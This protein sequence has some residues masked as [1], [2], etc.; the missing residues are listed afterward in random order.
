M[1]AQPELFFDNLN[2]EMV[3]DVRRVFH[4]PAKRQEPLIRRDRPWEGMLSFSD[5]AWNVLYDPGERLYRCWYESAHFD[6]ERIRQT[7]VDITDPRVAG[8]RICYACSV[9]GLHWEKPELDVFPIGGHPTN[10]VFGDWEAGEEEFGSVHAITVLDD[11]WDAAVDR[12]FKMIFQHVT[13]ASPDV[14]VV[15]DPD[16]DLEVLQSPIR[17]ATSPDGIHWEADA[18]RLDF[19]GHGPRLGDVIRLRQAEKNGR[20]VLHTRHHRAWNPPLNPGNPRTTAWSLPYYP[21]DPPKNNKR[22]IWRSESDDLVTWEE[23]YEVLVPDDMDDNLDDSY[24]ALGVFPVG[25]AFLGFAN[26]LHLVEGG[27]DVELMYSRD[28][29]SWQRNVLGRPFIPL[30]EP[31]AWDSCLVS[32]PFA[33]LEV[34]DE[35]RVYY[36][37]ADHHHNYWLVGNREGLDLPE[38]HRPTNF[39]EGMGLAVMRKE[40]FVSLNATVREGIVVTRPL[41]LREANLRINASCGADGYVDVEVVAADDTPLPGLSRTEF[42]RF[43]GDAIR[44]SAAWRSGAAI[45]TDRAV[46]LRFFMRHSHLYS[47]VI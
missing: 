36:G 44:H 18:R 28:E 43:S 6:F 26:T 47:M 39:S 14:D 4:K 38:V 12:R 45:P 31:G 19:G 20:Y 23:P 1:S 11:R 7:N 5:A 27:G 40:G 8:S 21:G 2:I 9:D 41:A 24:N 13:A 15:P 33:P 10:I 46:K 37:G 29:R 17:L 22:R 16:S 30:G 25:E 42:V 3:Q 35:L 32:A 34:D